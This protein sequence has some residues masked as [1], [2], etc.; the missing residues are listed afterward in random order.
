MTFDIDVDWEAYDRECLQNNLI[1]SATIQAGYK[2]SFD[3]RVLSSL[4]NITESI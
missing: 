1:D 2:P 4:N 3:I